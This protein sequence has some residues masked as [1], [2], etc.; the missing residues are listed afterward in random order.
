MAPCASGQENLMTSIQTTI[1]PP[2]MTSC[3]A[4]QQKARSEDIEATAAPALTAPSV[5][6]RALE[7]VQAKA[8][9]LSQALRSGDADERTLA[10]Q[11]F[12]SG[13]NTL[14]ACD[15][16]LTPKQSQDIQT[17]LAL[18]PGLLKSSVGS[19]VFKSDVDL[20]DLIAKYIGNINKDYLGVYENVV[21]QYTAFYKAFSEILAKMGG[22]ISPGSDS[23][24]VKLDVNALKSALLQ[25]QT[26]FS[27][28]NKDA[29]LFPAADSSGNVTGT[30]KEKADEWADDLG[31]PR[32]CVKQ[33]ADGSYVVVIDMAP[34]NTMIDELNKLGTPGS[35][36]K[37][38][39]D[40]AKFQAWQSG[41]KSQ[42]ENLKN[43]LQTLTQKYSNANS[44]FDN[45][46]KVLSSTISSCLETCKAFLQ[47]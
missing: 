35:D 3:H 44:L 16:A 34:I 18:L 31:V 22:W 10:T 19:T 11:Q 41:F 46:V 25:L 9:A 7:N 27:L 20:W 23:N 47:V 28:S 33:L 5:K 29:I 32:S 8:D 14:A 15:V 45:L 13:L 43:T 36:G 38:E 40:N 30:T 4:E 2:L 42:E 1:T 26:K 39:L 12:A 37:L 21:G 24:K 6:Q 17:E